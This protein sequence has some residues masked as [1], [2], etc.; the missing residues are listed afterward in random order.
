MSCTAV[1]D[2]YFV[3]GH[4]HIVMGMSAIFGMFAG[5]YHWYPKMFGTMMNTRLGFAHFWLT[6]VCGYGVFFP[7][8]FV[9]LA[10]SPRRYYDESQFTYLDGV[11][12]LQPIISV[13][14]IIGSI[15]QILF[16]FNFFYSIFRGQKATEN[17][18]K[19]NTLEWTTPVEHIHGNWPGALPEVHRWAYDYSNPDHEEDFVLQTTP[20]KKGEHAH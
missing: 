15:A 1:H 17:P 20:L 4:F 18:W 8:H 11:A 6:L 7:M 19:A 2:T 13:F 10:G 12:D 14:A 9:G 5:V 3:V 16:L